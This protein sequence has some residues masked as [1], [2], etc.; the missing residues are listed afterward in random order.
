MTSRAGESLVVVVADA[1]ALLAI[2]MGHAASK[3][4]ATP[5]RLHTAR[6]TWNEAMEYLPSFVTRYGVDPEIMKERSEQLDIRIWEKTSYRAQMAEAAVFMKDPDDVELAALALHLK[7]PV[8][9][10]DNHFKGFP[11]GRYTTAEI[12]KKLGF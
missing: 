1:N 10:N 5:A 2:L 7:A 6:F 12:L 11:T 9:S 8:W 3:V 4:L